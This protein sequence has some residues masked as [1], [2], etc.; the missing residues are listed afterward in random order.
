VIVD[1]G[2]II[3]SQKTISTTKKHLS[4]A[5]SAIGQVFC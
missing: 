3:F 1:C 2:A 4:T 5:D